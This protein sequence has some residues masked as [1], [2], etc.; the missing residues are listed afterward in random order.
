M[1]LYW[2]NISVK[3]HFHRPFQRYILIPSFFVRPARRW[4][5]AASL[6][7]HRTTGEHTLASSLLV[8][9]RPGNPALSSS[10]KEAVIAISAL[11]MYNYM[12]TFVSTAPSAHGDRL[13]LLYIKKGFPYTRPSNTRVSQ[14]EIIHAQ[15]RRLFTLL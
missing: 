5:Q 1:E 15:R 3:K 6:L 12:L 9:L 8:H 14:E 4:W 10:A 2:K 7:T 11:I 13:F